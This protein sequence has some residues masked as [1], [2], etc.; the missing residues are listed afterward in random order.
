MA[1]LLGD[2]AYVQTGSGC[3]SDIMFQLMHF[4][5]FNVSAPLQLSHVFPPA[6]LMI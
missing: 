4:N 5:I 3:V 6:N 2:G 1:I